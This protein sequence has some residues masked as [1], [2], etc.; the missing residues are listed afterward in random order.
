MK[1]KLTITVSLAA[2]FLASCQNDLPKE[3]SEKEAP[4][5]IRKK[6]VHFTSHSKDW[7]S[8]TSTS[9]KAGT[10]HTSKSKGS[11]SR[12]GFSHGGGCSGG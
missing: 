2:I 12:G 8:S 10:P 3:Q 9:D 4:E 5:E 6:S 1:K 11:V 7:T